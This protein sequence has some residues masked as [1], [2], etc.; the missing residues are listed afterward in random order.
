MVCKDCGNADVVYF[1]SVCGTSVKESKGGSKRIVFLLLLITVGLFSIMLSIVDGIEGS[2]DPDTY[3]TDDEH[4]DEQIN[5][6]I[7]WKDEQPGDHENWDG[8]S[9]Q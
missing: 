4:I 3:I 5:D 9:D 2:D 6:Y 1:C 7:E 8:S